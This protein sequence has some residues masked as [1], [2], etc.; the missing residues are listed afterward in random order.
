M[1]A[2]PGRIID[3]RAVPFARPRTIEM[4]YTPD[5]VALTHDLREA[6]FSNRGA[7]EAA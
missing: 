7:K 5:F 2:R 1:Q 6:I 4:T 3:D